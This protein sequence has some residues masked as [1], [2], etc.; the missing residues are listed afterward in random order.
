[1]LIK[2]I[3]ILVVVTIISLKISD[4][5]FNKFFNPV[6]QIFGDNGIQRSLILKEYNPNKKSI[7]VPPD[8][9]ISNSNLPIK[10]QYKLNIDDNGFIKNGNNLGESNNNKSIIFFGGS[11]TETLYVSETNRFVSVVERKLSKKLDRNIVL[12]NGGVSGNNTLH[13]LLNLIGKGIPL[14]PEYVVLMHNGTDL[15]LLRKSGSYWSAPVSRSIINIS[16]NSSDGK[17]IYYLIA[18]EIKNFLAPN[19]WS[20]LRMKIKKK[21]GLQDDFKSI[22]DETADFENVKK[23]F[24]SALISFVNVSKAWGIKPVL[25]TEFSRIKFNDEYFIK[26][27]PY[28]DRDEYIEQ[29]HQLNN[30]IREVAKKEKVLIIDLARQIP[31]SDEF[32]YDVIHLNENGSLL[33]ADIISEFFEKILSDN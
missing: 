22:R 15:S 31:S 19:I 8:H 13:S 2:K 14:N 17:N 32:I 29:Y 3:L 24:R 6:V 21:N 27:Y 26:N 12:Y 25:M 33:A 7:L 16:Q 18:R 30:I 5:V 4:I 11:T 1:M 9:L 20:F 23:M 10:K 28:Q